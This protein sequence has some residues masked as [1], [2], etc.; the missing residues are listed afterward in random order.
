MSSENKVNI[1]VLSIYQDLG[2]S[3][4]EMLTPEQM[5]NLAIGNIQA[6][7]E[8][9]A[10]AP[11][12][13]RTFRDRITKADAIVLVV[14]FLDV[15][16]LEKIKAIYRELPTEI[17]IPIGIVLLRDP[18][19]IDFKISCPACGQKL[20]LRDTDVGKRGRCPNCKKPFV[21]MSQ[22][23][24][25]KSQLMLGDGMLITKVTRGD[26]ASF[27]KA[28]ASLMKSV[29]GEIRPMVADSHAEALKNVTARIEIPEN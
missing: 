4:V 2:E 22:A 13:D 9:I 14:R 6:S 28:I 26:L 20:W 5:E 23:E 12:Q 15:L 11:S 27:E 18:G 3:F 8:V 16:S 17:N 21:I 1:V 29:S 7:M 19:E 10:G 25:I 24:H